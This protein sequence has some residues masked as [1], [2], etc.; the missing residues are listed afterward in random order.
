MAA[1]DVANDTLGNVTHGGC[2]AQSASSS[3]DQVSWVIAISLAIL[4]A[5]SNNL[6]VNFQKL[7]WTLKQKDEKKNKYRLVWLF[8]MMGIILASVFD[9]VALA[10]GPQSV[11]A[12]LG[13]LTMVLNGCIAPFMHG[14]KLR[15]KIVWTT[16]IIVTGCAMA[17]ATASHENVICD[18]DGIFAYFASLTF[19]G[20]A[21]VITFM[22]CTVALF[23]RRAEKILTVHGDDGPK[24]ER[25]F[26]YHR[27]SY[28]FLAGLFGAQSVVFARAIGQLVMSSTRGGQFFLVRWETWLILFALIL[29]I[30][31][32]MIYLNKGLERFESSY[33]VPVFTGTFI[34]ST[35]VAGGVVYGEFNSFSQ[36]QAILF[37]LGVGLCVLGVFALAW[38]NDEEDGVVDND[39]V[40]S[41]PEIQNDVSRPPS[42][43]LRTPRSAS[44]R[45]A[46][47][48]FTPF[49]IG[50]VEDPVHVHH[51]PVRKSIRASSPSHHLGRDLLTGLRT[52][53][54][55]N[56]LHGG[57]A[58]PFSTNGNSSGAFFPSSSRER[59]QQR[60]PP[61]TP[62]SSLSAPAGA[63][64]GFNN[65]E[66]PR[67]SQEAELKQR[68]MSPTNSKEKPP[69]V[70]TPSASPP[71]TG[72]NAIA[73]AIR[74]A[75]M[76]ELLR[77]ITPKSNIKPPEGF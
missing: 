16:F 68:Q 32:Q 45:L 56:V 24:Y 35:A 17:V 10:F 29:M 39:I 42:I 30:V 31:I 74:T 40:G 72:G 28:A 44:L 18:L 65:M 52:D 22:S 54:L 6:G 53:E 14:E 12:P 15:R 46:S 37:P 67:S 58:P 23:I 41:I 63:V 59:E 27:V 73:V 5:I 57:V 71:S 49:V 19:L 13:S 76:N 36:L 3:F 38:G 60:Y 64:T 77:P 69:V 1:G 21:I 47:G 75:S 51:H 4:A 9:F 25:I 62:R 70:P 2:V 55:I 34:V 20:Y 66:S 33:N 43:T 61:I 50:V 48:G 26:K 11:I 8:G 7:A